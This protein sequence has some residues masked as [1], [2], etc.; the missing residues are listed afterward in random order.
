GD[1]RDLHS[2]P[3]RR[4]SDLK[5]DEWFGERWSSRT[6]EWA[7]RLNGLPKY[8]V[9]S[10]LDEPVWGN[11][12]VPQGAV[13]GEVTRVKR[14]LDGELVAFA[15]RRLAQTLLEHD[16]VDEVRLTVYP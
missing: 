12:T 5:T 15:S 14:E 9:S 11:S 7:D 6:G 10:R 4:S 13:V 1:Q 2:F 16:L 8:V 3:T